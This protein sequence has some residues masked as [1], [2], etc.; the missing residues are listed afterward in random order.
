MNDS[1]PASID[2]D[3]VASIHY[4]LTLQDGNEVDTSRGQDP[5]LYLHGHGNIIPGLENALA[6]HKIGDSFEVSIPPAEA[7]GP[8]VEDA[9]QRVPRSDLPDGMEVEVGMQLGAQ[10]QSGE[11]LTLHVTEVTETDIEVDPNHPLAGQTLNFAVEV[12]ALRNASADEL[13]AGHPQDP[14][15]N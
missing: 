5:L 12:V 7:Y 8:R 15:G 4:T 11:T 13:E 9:M 2:A 10:T 1:N 3:V 14:D 6:G